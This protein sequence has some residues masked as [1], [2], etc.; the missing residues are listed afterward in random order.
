VVLGVGVVLAG[1]AVWV[2]LSG[3]HSI[4]RVRRQSGHSV[5][6]A[7][8][9]PRSRSA[10]R[11]VSKPRGP[12]AVGL[13]VL[14]LIDRSR[15][16]GGGPRTLVTVVRYPAVGRASNSDLPNA[17]PERAAGPFPLV[18]FAHG[19]RLAPYTYA[20]LLQTWAHAGFVVAAP[21]F[22]LTSANAPVVDR[23][24]LS[25]QPEDLRFV[26][27]QLLA[28]RNAPLGGLIDGARI[29]LGGHSDG[30]DTALAVAYGNPEDARIRAAL[31]F[32]GAEISAFT[33]FSG[34]P[35]GVP[36]LAVQ[37]TA[38]TVNAPSGTYSYFA[39]APRPKYLLKLLGAE[40]TAP[41]QEE[42][43]HL[44]IVERVSTAFLDTYL[45]GEAWAGDR[46]A[47]LGS[48]AG[49]STIQIER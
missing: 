5:G 22:P 14:R 34:R 13:L 38:D 15:L 47:A 25:N 48:V 8:S 3:G 26:M 7:I 39:D 24:D 23:S 40:H 30:V 20:Q 4:Q 2:A 12:F 28:Q 33:G 36:L 17:P 32:S 37:G 9:H 45:K 43:P 29:A 16:V 19:Y 41:Y 10:T 1:A 11:R 18:I 44:G 27:S 21:F 42:Q 35:H 49:L 31:G 6:R 46:L